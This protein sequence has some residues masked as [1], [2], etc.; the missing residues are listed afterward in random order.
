AA[1][2]ETEPTGF[3]LETLIANDLFVWRDAA[4]G[5]SVYHWRVSSGQEVDFVLE[6]SRNLVPVEIKSGQSVG[7]SDARHLRT[8]LERHANAPLGVLVSCDPEIRVLP[9]P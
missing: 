1:S 9:G 2:R 4:P 5:R 8:F 6:E 7:A 3:H